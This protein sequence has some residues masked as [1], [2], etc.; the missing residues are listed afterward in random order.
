[1]PRDPLRAGEVIVLASL[2]LAALLGFIAGVYALAYLL[3]A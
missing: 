3:R 1:M 2:T